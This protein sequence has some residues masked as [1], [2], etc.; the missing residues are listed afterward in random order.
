MS[1]IMTFDRAKP[2][3]AIY[4]EQAVP[5]FESFMSAFRGVKI[6]STDPLVIEY[7]S[8]TVE[9]DAENNAFNTLFPS[10]AYGEAPWTSI[11]VANRAE[12]AGEISWSADKAE[13]QQIEQT[14]F[15]GGPALEI[16]AKH[17][18]EAATASEIPY[19]PTLGQ[20]I[21]ADEASARYASL[22]SFYDNQNHF[23]LG[24]GP[25]FLDQ[26]FLTEKTLTL[27]HFD[28]FPDSADRWAGFSEP[29][30]AEATIDGPGQVKIGEEATFDI[31]VTFKGEPYAQADI[32]QVKYLLYNATGEVVKV[33]TAEAAA[34][35]QYTVTLSAEDTAALTAGSNKLEVAVIPLPVAVP[36]FS[37]IEFVTAP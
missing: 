24:T 27:S 18:G 14:S 28:D 11:A 35:G 32:K 26:V 7:Y 30:L 20:Y 5:V 25:Y 10:Y 23:W 2:E 4:D 37:S 36:T 22:Q 34:D 16:L 15:I 9:P 17:L 19:E 8:D 31:F 21:T 1:L 13:A 12:A 29:K 6:I 3:S 33:G